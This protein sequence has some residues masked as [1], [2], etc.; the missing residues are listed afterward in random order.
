MQFVDHEGDDRV[1]GLGHHADAV[2]LPQAAGEVF[3]RP[4]KLKSFLFDVEH[5]PHV[6]SNHPTDVDANLFLLR[7]C[8]GCETPACG[9]LSDCFPTGQG[10]GRGRRTVAGTRR[11]AKTFWRGKAAVTRAAKHT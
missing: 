2:A 10:G 5:F 4:R 1:A 11:R 3:V 8:H 9:D 6:T 7:H